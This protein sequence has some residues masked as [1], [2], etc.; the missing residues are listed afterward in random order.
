MMPKMKLD[1]EQQLVWDS[2][3]SVAVVGSG[4][5]FLLI[6]LDSG[7]PISDEATDDA[8]RRALRSWVSWPS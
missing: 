3:V 2:E 8:H 7:T 5:E 1:A 6:P 4:D